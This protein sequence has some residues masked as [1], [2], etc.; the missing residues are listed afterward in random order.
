MRS[1]AQ[2]PAT[3]RSREEVGIDVVYDGKPL[4]S[5]SYGQFVVSRAD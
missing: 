3:F 2:S 5:C 4:V 1:V